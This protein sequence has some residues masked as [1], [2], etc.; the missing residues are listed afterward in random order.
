MVTQLFQQSGRRAFMI[1]RLSYW[2]LTGSFLLAAGCTPGAKHFSAL[3]NSDVEKRREAA[4]Q[5]SKLE[6]VNPK[7]L[8]QLLDA[9]EDN[10]AI[11][12]EFAIKAIGK[13]DPKLDGVSRAIKRGLH[14][15]DISVR[16][17]SAAIF[18][19]MNPVPAEVLITL[20]EV[21][22]DKDSLL[23]TFVGS[24]FIDLGPI[25]VNALVHMCKNGNVDLRCRAVM[26]LGTIGCE[27]KRALPALKELL[28]D[29]DDS[30]RSAAQQ[31]IDR[32][33]LS[34]LCPGQSGK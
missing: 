34:Y 19:T 33:Q 22:A 32:I 10:D 31:S 29:Q 16:R 7:K 13:M 15:S 24:T 9:A 27:A 2:F 11:V 26:T 18:S 1:H 23:R 25:G 4:F 30:V 8:P 6:D 5:V 21:L 17:A 20:A 3:K 28:N 14:D 12:R